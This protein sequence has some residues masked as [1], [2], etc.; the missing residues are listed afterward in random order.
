MPQ[1]PGLIRLNVRVV[2]QKHHVVYTSLVRVAVELGVPVVLPRATGSDLRRDFMWLGE[3]N[4]VVIV[5]TVAVANVV[6]SEKVSLQAF[7]GRLRGRMHGET[8]ADTG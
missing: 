8:L 6:A 3:M 5:V 1:T 2:L 4:I 7:L